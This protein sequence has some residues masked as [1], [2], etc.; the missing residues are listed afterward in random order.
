MLYSGKQVYVCSK[1]SI[2]TVCSKS[3]FPDNTQWRPDVFHS[4][5]ERNRRGNRNKIASEEQS[6]FLSNPTPIYGR[7]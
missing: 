7:R 6:L 1:P 5:F 3:N 2:E 4:I